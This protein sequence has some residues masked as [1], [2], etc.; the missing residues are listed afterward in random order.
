MNFIDLDDIADTDTDDAAA[1]DTLTKANIASLLYQRMGINKRESRELVDAFFDE[2]RLSLLNGVDVKISSFG[3]FEVRNKSSRPGRN[4]RT[5]E[6]VPVSARAV[7]SF[8]PSLKLKTQVS[9]QHPVT[10]FL[11]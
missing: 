6:L 10:D 2:I 7:V 3:N 4:P 11:V 8:H 5:G 1:L 9:N